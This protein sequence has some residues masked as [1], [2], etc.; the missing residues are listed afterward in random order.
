MKSK[1]DG[2][3]VLSLCANK[4]FLFRTSQTLEDQRGNSDRVFMLDLLGS[5]L[6]SVPSIPMVLYRS[7]NNN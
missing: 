6:S 7:D 5:R 3:I 1:E 2:Q 4:R